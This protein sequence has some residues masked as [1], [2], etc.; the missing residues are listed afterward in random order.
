MH[1]Y[2]RW[3]VAHLPQCTPEGVD[4]VIAEV[5]S[6]GFV[7]REICLDPEGRIIRC[8]PTRQSSSVLLGNR[9]LPREKLAQHL[10]SSEF[11]AL[12]QN[13]TDETQS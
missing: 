4:A 8:A 10:D 12:W 7:C 3:T 9:A 6:D 13:A 5:C 11:E 1:F 2:K